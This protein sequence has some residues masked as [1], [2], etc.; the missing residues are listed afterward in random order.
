LKEEN[1]GLTADLPPPDAEQESKF[2]AEQHRPPLTWAGEKLRPEYSARLFAGK[3][4]AKPRPFLKARMPA[5]PRRAEML[6]AGLS[7]EHGF[8]LGSPKPE[9]PDAK[10]AEVGRSLSAKGKWGCVGCHV[11]GKAEAVGVFEA[12]GVNFADVQ[13]RLRREYFDRWLWAP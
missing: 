13:D 5:F 2:P 7:A 8:G 12:P 4:P 1:D 9:K 3:L 11:V 10:L 6:A